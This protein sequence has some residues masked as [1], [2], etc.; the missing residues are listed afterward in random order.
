MEEGAFDVGAAGKVESSFKFTTESIWKENA[1]GTILT[2][3]AKR[4]AKDATPENTAKFSLILDGSGVGMTIW[5][6]L[7]E[8]VSSVVPHCGMYF[9]CSTPNGRR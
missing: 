9:L 7:R 2:I 1:L 3:F 6:L 4:F 8:N 5:A